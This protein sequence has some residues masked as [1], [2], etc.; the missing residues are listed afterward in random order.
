VAVR[1]LWTHAATGV[2]GSQ[3]ADLHREMDLLG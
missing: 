2:L 3:E 1:A